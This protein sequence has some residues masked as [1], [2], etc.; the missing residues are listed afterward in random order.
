MPNSSLTPHWF[1]RVAKIVIDITYKIATSRRS[2]NDE[3][4]ARDICDIIMAVREATL[5]DYDASYGVYKPK[6]TAECLSCIQ[7][8]PNLGLFL[9][10]TPENSYLSGV[11][12]KDISYNEFNHNI[13]ISVA[14]LFSENKN[15]L[16]KILKQCGINNSKIQQTKLLIVDTSRDI[17]YQNFDDKLL[18]ITTKKIRTEYH[19]FKDDETYKKEINTNSFSRLLG[20]FLAYP[21]IHIKYGI[22]LSDIQQ[23]Y[24]EK[25]GAGKINITDHMPMQEAVLTTAAIIFESARNQAACF[26]TLASLL[27]GENY[28]NLG[29]VSAYMYIGS[30][31]KKGNTD[32]YDDAYSNNMKIQFKQLTFTKKTFTKK[33][34][35]NLKEYRD[36]IKKFTIYLE[37]LLPLV[38]KLSNKNYTIESIREELIKINTGPKLEES[39]IADLITDYLRPEWR[40]L[41]QWPALSD[42]PIVEAL[43]KITD[44]NCNQCYGEKISEVTMSNFLPIID[45]KL[46][47]E[48]LMSNIIKDL[49]TNKIYSPTL[50]LRVYLLAIASELYQDKIEKSVTELIGQVTDQKELEF[51]RQFFNQSSHDNDYYKNLVAIFEIKLEAFKSEITLST[52]CSLFLLKQTTSPL[53]T[54]HVNDPDL[55]EKITS[56]LDNIATRYIENIKQPGTWGGDIE[57]GILANYYQCKI[58]VHQNNS[59]DLEINRDRPN[60]LHLQYNGTHYCP[61][62]NFGTPQ[63]TVEL[64]ASNGDCLFTSIYYAMNPQDKDQGRKDCENTIVNMRSIVELCLRIELHFNRL[65]NQEHQNS[66]RTRFSNI[67]TNPDQP[68]GLLHGELLEEARGLGLEYQEFLKSLRNQEDPQSPPSP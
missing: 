68:S 7:V 1:N 58:V 37:A 32:N 12:E 50:A 14:I 43:L 16:D 3:L 54:P 59:P 55:L 15:M 10:V 20:L 41:L 13:K 34:E 2:P 57:L 22:K 4:N 26:N 44:I 52:D 48:T 9:T 23:V 62:H 47:N 8:T 61:I 38:K 11:L 53:P 27:A 25:P 66:I 35:F 46:P 24:A 42:L 64:V 17:T 36:E 6:T 30:N 5:D 49:I 28:L 39:F 65:N 33:E 31:W 67:I 51:C 19:R 21:R 63:K 40:E 29:T 18:I 45:F 56:F 60:T